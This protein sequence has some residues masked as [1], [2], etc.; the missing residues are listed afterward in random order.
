MTPKLLTVYLRCFRDDYI[1][2]R[3]LACRSSQFL[4]EKHAKVIDSL[5]FMAR[6]DRVNKLKALAIRSKTLQSKH[7][8]TKWQQVLIFVL[9]SKKAIGLV[10]D[11]NDEIRKCLLWALQFELD[12]FIRT[13]ACHC[14]LLLINNLKDQ[15]LVDILLERYLVEGEAMVRR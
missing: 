5:V 11:F 12:P 9:F 14:I 10:G 1:S 13:E 6:F 3:E 8:L 4:N 2:V 15:E 7:Y